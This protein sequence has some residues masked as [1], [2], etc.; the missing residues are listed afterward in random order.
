VSG[1]VTQLFQ[2]V[3]VP[4]RPFREF[5]FTNA[6]LLH[7]RNYPDLFNGTVLERAVADELGVKQASSAANE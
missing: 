3:T 1:L 4:A 2:V 6:A 5:T 7:T